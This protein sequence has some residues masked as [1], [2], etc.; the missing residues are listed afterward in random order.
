MDDYLR[1]ISLLG[2]GII[3]L[4]KEKAEELAEELV[5]QGEISEEEGKNLMAD[6]L[7]RSNEQKKEFDKRIEQEMKKAAARLN[8]ATKEDIDRLE[9]KIAS[10]K[11]K[12]KK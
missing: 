9:K 11:K 7:K 12:K 8:L 4:T 5:K 3:T 2:M 6:L 10:T 1:K